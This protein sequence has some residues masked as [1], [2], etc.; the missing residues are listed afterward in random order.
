MNLSTGLFANPLLGGESQ[1]SRDAGKEG[2]REKWGKINTREVALRLAMDSNK[3]GWLLFSL[4]TQLG[5]NRNIDLLAPI[6][7]SNTCPLDFNPWLPPPPTP[8]WLHLALSEPTK[9]ARSHCR[10]SV[11]RWVTKPS[12]LLMFAC[13]LAGTQTLLG[14]Q[15][16]HMGAE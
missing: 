3:Y 6:S 13:L 1:D 5:G 8:W 11:S 15:Q 9:E 4:S 12:R 7:I 14:S 16:A 2:G 10:S